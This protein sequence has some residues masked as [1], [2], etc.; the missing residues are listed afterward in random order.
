MDLLFV[1]YFCCIR[2]F[3]YRRWFSHKANV[4]EFVRTLRLSH[5]SLAIQAVS[6]RSP[7]A[8]RGDLPSSPPVHDDDKISISRLALSASS[9]FCRFQ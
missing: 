4:L 6:R 7:G 3:I 9:M 8:A 2:V 1:I 5:T